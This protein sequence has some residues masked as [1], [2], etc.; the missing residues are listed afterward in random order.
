MIDA[1]E[2]G[3]QRHLVD[4]ARV[5]GYLACRGIIPSFSKIE[6]SNQTRGDSLSEASMFEEQPTFRLCRDL[7][8][9]PEPPSL[10]GIVVVDNR[11]HCRLQPL[12]R[13]AI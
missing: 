6:A 4:G 8:G 12:A 11:Q 7:L 10:L 9:G 13:Q 5:P 1:Q 2:T 3:A